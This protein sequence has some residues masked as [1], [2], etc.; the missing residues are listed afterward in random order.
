MEIDEV[1]DSRSSEPQRE[2]K[3]LETPSKKRRTRT[4]TTSESITNLEV[5]LRVRPKSPSDASTSR[6]EII[7]EHSTIHL[8]AP[9]QT[10]T[11]N[12]SFNYVFD[13]NASN[14]QVFGKIGVNVIDRFLSG[15]TN[16]VFTYGITGSGKTHTITGGNQMDGLLPNMIRG[17]F[18]H[19]SMRTSTPR[20]TLRVSYLENYTK[21]VLDL[22]CNTSAGAGVADDKENQ[23]PPPTNTT[24]DTSSSS[25]TNVVTVRVV[26]SEHVELCN[27]SSIAVD[28]ADQ[29]LTLIDRGNRRRATAHTKF[30]TNS[31][32]SHALFVMDLCDLND[33]VG[34]VKSRLCIVD[35]AGSENV[36]KAGF[37]A[38]DA[39]F[40]ESR[41]I[42]SSLSVLGRCLE[43]IQPQQQQQQQHVPWRESSL[44][45]ILWQYLHGKGYVTMIVTA[46]ITDSEYNETMRALEFA[47]SSQNITMNPVVNSVRPTTAK[48][49]PRTLRSKASKTLLPTTATTT[50]ESQR[51]QQ[52]LSFIATCTMDQL[53]RIAI[54]SYKQVLRCKEKMQRF[55]RHRNQSVLR[56]LERL[57]QEKTQSSNLDVIHEQQQQQ[58]QHE[59]CER[60]LDALNALNANLSQELTQCACQL[61][62]KTAELKHVYHEQ[63]QLETQLAASKKACMDEKCRATFSVEE[64]TTRHAEALD[65]MQ[66]AHLAKLSD[67]EQ[68]M[69]S[70]RA[71]CVELERR[72]KAYEATQV[73]LTSD[74][75]A[76]HKRVAQYEREQQQQQQQQQQVEGGRELEWVTREHALRRE[77]DELS[78]RNKQLGV[79]N[80]E[81]RSAQQRYQQ[82]L[83]E[84]EQKMEHIVHLNR[85]WKAKAQQQQI[86]RTEGEQAHAK[87]VDMMDKLKAEH[88][89]QCGH[90]QQTENALRKELLTKQQIHDDAQ[91]EIVA[92]HKQ[93][94][95]LKKEFAQRGEELS[96]VKRQVAAKEKLYEQQQLLYAKDMRE[97]T[98][99]LSEQS[100]AA[101]STLEERRV[102]LRQVIEE[103]ERFYAQHCAKQHALKQQVEEKDEQVRA[104][105]AQLDGL[106][107]Q[108]DQ[109][110]DWQ[111]QYERLQ[112]EHRRLRE[113][114]RQQQPRVTVLRDMHQQLKHDV[115]LFVRAHGGDMSR[116]QESV[117]RLTSRHQGHTHALQ[118]KMAAVEQDYRRC[119]TTHAQ[120]I[121]AKDEQIERWRT[122]CGAQQTRLE[123]AE[124]TFASHK[125]EFEREHARVQA[126]LQSTQHELQQIG[127]ERDAL[128]QRVSQQQEQYVAQQARH[129][130]ELEDADHEFLKADRECKEMHAEKDGLEQTLQRVRREHDTQIEALQ[131]RIV[132]LQQQ[133][134][135]EME[136][137]VA[138]KEAQS[139]QSETLQ[140]QIATLNTELQTLKIR[141][142]SEEPAHANS[143][144]SSTM[145]GRRRNTS[146]SLTRK[147]S[148]R[149]IESENGENEQA[150]HADNESES[151]AARVCDDTNVENPSKKRKVTIDGTHLSM[152]GSAAASVS[153]NSHGAS[154]IVIDGGSDASSLQPQNLL[155]N[156]HISDAN[157]NKQEEEEEEDDDDDD[158]EMIQ[159][160]TRSANKHHKHHNHKHHCATHEEKVVFAS[161]ALS[162]LSE[163]DEPLPKAPNTRLRKALRAQQTHAAGKHRVVRTPATKE[164]KRRFT[165]C[166]AAPPPT[167]TNE[168]ALMGMTVVNLRQKLKK[169]NLK[170]RGNKKEL[171][172]TLVSHFEQQQQQNGSD[173]GDN[174][175]SKQEAASPSTESEPLLQSEMVGRCVEERDGNK[176]YSAMRIEGVLYR[177]GDEVYINSGDDDDKCWLGAI[178]SL[179]EKEDGER[180][181]GNS[182]Y[183]SYS[184][185]KKAVKNK[186]YSG[187]HAGPHEVFLSEGHPPDNN[188]I[189]LVNYKRRFKVFDTQKSMD[190]WNA[191]QP[192][193][194]VCTHFC[195][196]V[197]NVKMKAL[198]PR[199]MEQ[200]ENGKIERIDEGDEQQ[201][202]S[203]NENEDEDDDD[204]EEE[205]DEEEEEDTRSKDKKKRKATSSS[206]IVSVKNED[207]KEVSNCNARNRRNRRRKRTKKTM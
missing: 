145:S 74:N 139:K 122:K 8:H 199:K 114:C 54:E 38:N 155:R 197:Y 52:D 161:P 76:L 129:R 187:W 137:F 23:A 27:L 14:Q 12:Y 59:E 166:A 60:K 51:L 45:K 17:I 159:S 128:E 29:A 104:L 35:L 178:V 162:H 112:S 69:Q 44:T 50:V 6:Y 144:S 93:F 164:S 13:E 33:D 3:C 15:Y 147:R 136:Q 67:M 47:A 156:P 56:L 75:E 165:A 77:I 71:Q 193:S 72:I 102:E 98:K 70:K 120:L 183:W 203:E 94:D 115:D 131:T 101:Q 133:H 195:Q 90:A 154:S 151:A 135:R 185:I 103:K 177:V 73:S 92:L 65:E 19:D 150:E 85:E 84:S 18:A 5:F 175:T 189:A 207:D 55:A 100:Q 206:T 188:H 143:S 170:C 118:Q 196:Y 1:S 109:H 30:N 81:L 152:P 86:E 123:Q 172:H 174:D 21:Y 121:A 186:P 141:N 11:R 26:N 126:C 66:R 49:K 176:Y 28:N 180:Y 43:C 190:V 163:G 184:E 36:K 107:Q 200:Q 182:W 167:P 39:R 58:Q 168:D 181:M 171:V 99:Q 204:D 192:R 34:A 130:A 125:Q 32:R 37:S 106:Q 108:V 64:A 41:G 96:N 83:D 61:E 142:A 82:Q 198:I 113:T 202:D 63:Q 105:Y 132:A 119:Q 201:A 148:R 194:D 25:S 160:P 169:R 68:A 10:D 7:D 42:N 205:E 158:E 80:D 146:S 191:Q 40:Q 16:L 97:L 110:A 116:C 88:A 95:A 62:E 48:K 46:H 157:T 4:Q 31:S 91:K 124:T 179:Y 89:A 149:H 9:N 153:G 79:D 22:L 2:D 173:D 140:R 134:A 53:R 24:T 138:L 20:Y 57:E 127:A 78:Q 87:L 111:E 117:T